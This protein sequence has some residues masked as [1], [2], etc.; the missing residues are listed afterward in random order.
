MSTLSVDTIQGQTTAANVKL[1]AGTPLQLQNVQSHFSYQEVSTTSYVE[2][3]GMS[4]SITPKFANSK[5]KISCQVSWWL[6]TDASNYMFLTYYRDIGGGGYSNL[7]DDTTY[8]AMQFY[9]P[10]KNAA[11]NNNATLQFIDTPN[12]TSAVT[13]KLY[14][15]KYDGTNNVRLKYAQT[16]SLMTAEEISV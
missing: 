10:A 4:V 12:T 9:A 16:T 6:S 13:Y 5:I 7:A 1:P 2:V 15:R 3:T 14:C 11:L 8:D